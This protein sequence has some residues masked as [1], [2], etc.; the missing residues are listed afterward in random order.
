MIGQENE[1]G[2]LE[3]LVVGAEQITID[4]QVIIKC[5]E[6]LADFVAPQRLWGEGRRKG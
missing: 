2:R 5:G 6:F 4:H 3:F 1:L